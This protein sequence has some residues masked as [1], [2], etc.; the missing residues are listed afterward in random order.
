MRS[1]PPRCSSQINTASDL[2]QMAAVATVFAALRQIRTSVSSSK[3]GNRADMA[4][5]GKRG[6]RWCNA[7]DKKTESECVWQPEPRFVE[8]SLASRRFVVQKLKVS[9]LNVIK[10]FQAFSTDLP[11][12]L[13]DQGGAVQGESEELSQKHRKSGLI[14]IKVERRKINRQVGSNCSGV[15]EVLKLWPKF[16]LLN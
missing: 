8:T 15:W 2:D 10:V 3:L 9:K 6:L 4:S 13:Y 1:T 7:R 14:P 12:V 11:L 5:R 16:K